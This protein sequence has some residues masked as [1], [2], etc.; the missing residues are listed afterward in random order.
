MKKFMI[1]ILIL[2][3][4][5]PLM[6]ACGNE[7]QSGSQTGSEPSEET[8]SIDPNTIFQVEQKDM[9]DREFRILCWDFGYGSNSILG[10]TG[11]VLYNEENP[12]AVDEAKKQ[13]IDIIEERFNCKIAGTKEHDVATITTIRNQV[14]SA[15]EEGVS[16]DIIF[17]SLG[18]ITP[19]VTEQLLTDLK[20]IDTIDLSKPWW[21]QNA[22]EDLSLG[23]RLYCVAGDIN[24]Y[25]NQGTW[26]IV[27]NK[28]LK[29]SLGIEE[30]FYQMVR[31]GK[32]TYDRFVEICSR[33]GITA[34]LNGD[35]V[36]DEKDQWAFGTESYNM[37]VQVVAGGQKIALKDENDLPYLTVAKDPEET[38]TML[39]HIL[40]FYLQ[41][42]KVMC[43]N[44]SNYT[45]KGFSNVW[46]ET[47]HKAF[48]EGRELFYMCGLINI[49]SYREM[50]DDYGILPI[51]M[52][53][54]NQDS[55]HHTVSVSNDT[56]MAIPSG[57]VGLEDVGTIVS[58][59]SEESRK[60]VTPAYYDKQLK[61]RDARDEESAE[62]LDL[63]FSTRTFDLG[64]AYNWGGILGQYM[65]EN[66]NIQ[67]RFDAMIGS[68]ETAL[69]RTLE[70]IDE[71]NK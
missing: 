70:A 61:Y 2:A 30:D 62:M 65:A 15:Y 71:M 37:Y 66:S 55:Y 13:V 31:D 41:Y 23:G 39:E 40:D 44:F 20:T 53:Y 69:E 49:A 43:A 10:Y 67:S 7:D 17:D 38:Y 21:D 5:M 11:E 36:L 12:D 58:A 9:A 16:Y 35:G 56:V 60:Y 50:P 45:S 29:E 18:S 1:C 14:M 59:L 24:T 52:Y 54:E 4:V 19:L 63:I 34:E 25:D 48:I 51:P 47:V 6:F 32:W 27:F 46:E 28:N 8:T 3:L 68:A 33:E 26:C 22:V 64:A 57:V 42:D